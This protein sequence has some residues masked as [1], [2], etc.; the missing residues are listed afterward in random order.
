MDEEKEQSFETMNDKGVEDLRY[1]EQIA[2]YEDVL[3]AKYSPQNKTVYR[4]MHNPMTEDD[5]KPQ[6]EQSFNQHS[7]PKVLF[8]PHDAPLEVKKEV[9]DAFALSVFDSASE[10]ESFM[11]GIALSR[12]SAIQRARFVEKKGDY[13][14]KITLTE[15]D[16]WLENEANKDGH[17]NFHPYKDFDLSKHIGDAYKINL[18]E[19]DDE[20]D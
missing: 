20:E 6:V 5:G 11:M 1:Y 16:G 14:T 17:R 15:S 3:Q 9:V 7:K 13:V 10:C 8:L 18:K 4:M 19:N 2:Q 12:R